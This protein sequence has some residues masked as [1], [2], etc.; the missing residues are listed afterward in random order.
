MIPLGG[1]QELSVAVP[2]LRH[3]GEWAVNSLLLELEDGVYCLPGVANTMRS[4]SVAAPCLLLAAGLTS[5]VGQVSTS[6]R[7]S[8]ASSN[9]VCRP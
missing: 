4:R 3:G 1:A 7:H 6:G 8:L 2:E 9:Q 5:S